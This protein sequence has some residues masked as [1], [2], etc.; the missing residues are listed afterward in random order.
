MPDEILLPADGIYAGWYERPDGDVHPAAISLGRRPTFY[1]DAE[2]SLLEAY[3]LDFDGDLYGEP[4]KVRFVARLRGEQRF[5]SVDALIAQMGK[6]VDATRQRSPGPTSRANSPG[7]A[8]LRGTR[9]GRVRSG[10]V[11]VGRWRWRL[12]SDWRFLSDRR[13]SLDPFVGPGG[14]PGLLDLERVGQLGRRRSRASSRLRPCERSSEATTRTTGP[15][16][17]SSR[18]R[19]R[20]PSDGEF[21]TSKRTSARVLDVLACWP[22]GPPLPVNRH[23]SSSSG[24]WHD[25]RD[26]QVVGSR[27]G[28]AC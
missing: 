23:S 18:A 15:S 14:P 16:C 8:V 21:S 1:E 12:R 20:G 22:P 4:A 17:S 27:F 5:D 11:L 19:C 6:D 9:T 2:A 10:S 3:L 28:H 26:P 13:R 7:L 24:I 25:E